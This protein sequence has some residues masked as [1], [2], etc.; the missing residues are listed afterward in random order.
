MGKDG[1]AYRGAP[2][3]ARRASR[4]DV[5]HAALGGAAGC[6]V[7]RSGVDRSTR[8]RAGECRAGRRARARGRPVR[9]HGRRHQRRRAHGRR[10]APCSST[11]VRKPPARR[12]VVRSPALPGSGA[13]HTLFNTHWHPEQTGSN[14]TLAA[15]RCRP[16]SRRR[17]RGS[18]CRPTS[19]GRGTTKPS[20]RCPR[21]RARTGRSTRMASS[22]RPASRF[23]YGH[24]RD[25]PHTDGDCYVFFPEHNVLAVGRCA[26]RRQLADA[27]LVDGRLDRRARRRARAPLD[28][29]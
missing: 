29:C 9:R 1:R 11:A 12:C 27:R 28:Y 19:R 18:G 17:T 22:S 24:L 15:G 16:S 2:R 8:V 4:R 10:A 6:R 5:L 20:S 3:T 25:A 13:I 23:A 14:E 7:G 21:R 26:E